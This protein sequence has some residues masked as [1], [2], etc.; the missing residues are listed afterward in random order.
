MNSQEGSK[1]SSWE[2]Y[3]ESKFSPIWFDFKSLIQ[4]SRQEIKCSLRYS[5]E[6][7]QFSYV[8]ASHHC[9]EQI[10]ESQIFLGN[11]SGLGFHSCMDLTCMFAGSLRIV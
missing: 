9:P 7:T 4:S 2:I 10:S 11:E 3:L 8:A 6:T 5:E 1:Q